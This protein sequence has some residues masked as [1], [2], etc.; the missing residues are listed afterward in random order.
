[1]FSQ[2][3]RVLVVPTLLL[4][5]PSVAAQPTTSLTR[6]TGE[7]TEPFSNLVAVQE[8]PDGRAV[9]TDAKERTLSIVNFRSGEVRQLGRNGNGPNEY[10]NAQHLFRGPADTLYLFDFPAR[11]MLRITPTGTLAGTVPIEMTIGDTLTG[12]TP[13][14]NRI[15]A[16]LRYRDLAGRVYY[17][18]SYL[19]TTR[20]GVHPD[21][22]L[23]R[24]DPATKTS[25]IVASLRAWYPEESSRW[26]APFLYQDV[27]AVAA[28]GRVARVVPKDYHVEWYRD[29]TLMA[30]G[31]T[32]SV[33][34][35][36]VTAEDRRAWYDAR[37]QQG[38]ASGTMAGPSTPPGSGQ[39][40]RASPRRPPGFTDADFPSVKPPFVEDYVGRAAIIDPGANELWVTRAGA[41]NA[42]TST[43]DV[44]DAAGRLVRHVT[45][46]ATHRVAG[47]GRGTVYLVR[48]D[49]DGLQ[50]LEQYT[51]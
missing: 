37:A 35:V 15:V 8:L 16:G 22:Y 49:E 1:M 46:P 17:E 25:T 45:I 44:F 2:L 33:P 5:A 39:S 3:V 14:G 20:R 28:D 43:I 34:P 40:E 24:F 51:R 31:P 4:S 13:K 11:R 12:E 10:T 23:A 27:W 36:R 7:A 50:W 26:R 48:T 47:F 6:K 42:K 18:V 29:G 30:R 41:W 9:V 32:I 38:S 19:E 21:Q